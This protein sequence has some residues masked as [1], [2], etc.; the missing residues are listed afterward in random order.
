MN[1]KDKKFISF[2]QI[3]KVYY[4]GEEISK[5]QLIRAMYTFLDKRTDIDNY[6]VNMVLHTGSV[7]FDI[8][9]IVFAAFSNIFFDETTADDILES[10]EIGNFVIYNKERHKYLQKETRNGY[11]YI[12][13]ES[14]KGMS[15]LVRSD[16]WKEI[17]PYNGKATSLGGLG[18]RSHKN[19]EFLRKVSDYLGKDIPPVIK[20]ASVFIM[21]KKEA[22][23]YVQNISFSFKGVTSKLTDFAPSSYYTSEENFYQLGTNPLKSEPNL[24][25]TSRFS[26]ARKLFRNNDG[27]KKT[28][29]FITNEDLI[30]RYYSD[31]IDCLHK[32]IVPNNY[33][34]QNI[35]SESAID[36]I[37]EFNDLNLFACTEKLLKL[38]AE[39]I[40]KK[41]DK[42]N[43]SSLLNTFN[44]QILANANRNVETRI[45]TGVI[46]EDDF[47]KFR[48][49]LKDLKNADYESDE[50]N[51]FIVQGFALF[52]LFNSAVFSIKHLDSFLLSNTDDRVRNCDKRYE[53]LK[54]LITTFPNYL[55]EKLEFNLKLLEQMKEKFYENTPKQ[56]ALLELLKENLNSK[57]CI[58]IPKAYYSKIIENILDKDKIVHTN[59]K[60]VTANKFD[61]SELFDLIVSFGTFEGTHFNLFNCPS[62]KKIITILYDYEEKLYRIKEKKEQKVQKLFNSL[63][64]SPLKRSDILKEFNTVERE[65]EDLQ[66]ENEINEFIENYSLNFVNN[67][68]YQKNYSHGD[69]NIYLSDVVICVTFDNGEKAFLSKNYKPYIFNE[70]T[71]EVEEIDC[72]D[73]SEGDSVLFT[74]R[75]S[76]TSDLVQEFLIT[77][78]NEKRLS[79]EKT[80]AVLK[81]TEWR[82]SLKQYKESRHITSRLLAK[83]LSEFINKEE[84]TIKQWITPESHTVGPNSP[85]DIKQIGIFTGNEILEKNYQ[86]YFEACRI[87]RKIRR[88][89]LSNIETAIKLKLSGKIPDSRTPIYHIY[90]K[91]DSLAEIMQVESVIKINKQ[92]PVQLVNKPLKGDL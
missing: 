33:I 81:S 57:I 82:N 22:C 26:I 3:L 68:Y 5:S 73:L 63:T 88:E 43:L 10:I 30:H 72:Q 61:D 76:E 64:E 29:L 59:I 54:N 69:G 90:G 11:E 19:N 67:S 8:A 44:E 84:A 85:N 56:K 58:I 41:S 78:I 55:R 25:F 79:K 91:V 35:G 42:K 46:T 1:E 62:T 13:L 77:L 89:I 6:N 92:I 15:T 17:M 51:D 74:K 70:T 24:I 49:N 16:H 12:K 48:K 47:Y 66:T 14:A 9:T 7:I 45:I 32:K 18:V 52:N 31:L 86:D 65:N 2:L 53:L 40:K 27:N 23:E 4:N 36:I 21:S 38:Y 34:I 75:G 87:V 20:L 60:I 37:E 80:E 71:E 28:S 39:Q 83:Q 50:K